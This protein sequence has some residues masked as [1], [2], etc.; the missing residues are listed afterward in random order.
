[1]PKENAGKIMYRLAKQKGLLETIK[2]LCNDAR[3]EG[4]P[5]W[6]VVATNWDTA[7]MLKRLGDEIEKNP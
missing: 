4:E 7:M 6:G 2:I 5:I 3:K 1:M